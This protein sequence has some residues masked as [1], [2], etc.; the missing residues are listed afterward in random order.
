MALHA[1]EWFARDLNSKIIVKLNIKYFYSCVYDLIHGYFLCKNVVKM[2]KTFLF[3]QKMHSIIIYREQWILFG[4]TVSFLTLC[5]HFKWIPKPSG[6]LYQN[7]IMFDTLNLMPIY[8]NEIEWNQH[9]RFGW[10]YVFCNTYID[11]LRKLI[12]RWIYK[13]KL[14]KNAIL[15]KK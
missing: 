8:W 12:T 2:L 6:P 15:Q 9:G 4:L 5:S 13:K 10:R 11:L 3:S 7:S 14:M 1:N